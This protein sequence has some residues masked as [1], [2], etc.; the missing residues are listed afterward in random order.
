[1]YF[2]LIGTLCCWVLSYGQ[3]VS[4]KLKQAF[5]DQQLNDAVAQIKIL[6]KNTPEALMPRSFENDTLITSKTNWWTSGFYPGTLLY[7]YEYSG[8]RE[9]MQLVQ[10]K[11]K[12]LEKEKHNKNTHD[13]G[14]MLYCSYGNAL[15]IT[16][17]TAA[18][19]DILLTG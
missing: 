9:L 12:I 4:Y 8:D 19:K 11:F 1:S 2:L 3:S 5:I 17:D 14:F 10:E 18:Y 6:A 13:L 7:L 16:R 15:R